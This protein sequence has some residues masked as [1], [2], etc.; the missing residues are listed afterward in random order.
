MIET[1]TKSSGW[2]LSSRASPTILAVR[3]GGLDCAP[4]ALMQGHRSDAARTEIRAIPVGRGAIRLSRW[5]CTGDA[6]RSSTCTSAARTSAA[7]HVTSPV[8]SGLAAANDLVG[9]L[10]ARLSD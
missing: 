3:P 8:R 2:P 10:L 5:G 7:D 4:P 9:L 1:W 6:P